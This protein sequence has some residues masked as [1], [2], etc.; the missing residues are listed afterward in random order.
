MT[1]RLVLPLAEYELNYVTRYTSVTG[2]LSCGRMDG[3]ILD[4]GLYP[5]IERKC[6]Y[7]LCYTSLKSLVL[8]SF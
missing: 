5:N 8:P 7:K 2:P 6:G 3:S 4:E 1:G